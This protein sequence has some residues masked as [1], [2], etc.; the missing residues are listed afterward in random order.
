MHER[1]FLLHGLAAHR[2]VMMRLTSQ[3][4]RSGYDAKNWGYRSIRP[5]IGCHAERLCELLQASD[6]DEQTRRIHLVTHSM[7]S[8][9]ARVALS[10]YLP[11]KLGHIVMLGPPNR[12]SHTARQLAP[13]LGW[14]CPPL[15]E[16][17]D[18]PTSFVNALPSPQGLTIGIVAAAA[19]RVVARA[20]TELPGQADW[21][22]L[23]GQHGMLPYRED[24][25][26]QVIHFLRHG[27]FMRWDSAS[28]PPTTAP[29]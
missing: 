8:I 7:G 13:W 1:V 18:D 10:Q 19:D 3:L 29:C 12:G 9:I 15:Q 20:A 16:L 21:I 11:A 2:I 26:R 24:T 23:P 28:E 5:R 22:L 6:Q 25:A 27:N 17:S 14:L 4:G